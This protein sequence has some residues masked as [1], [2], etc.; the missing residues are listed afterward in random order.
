M[1]NFLARPAGSLSVCLAA[2]V[3]KFIILER[4]NWESLNPFDELEVRTNE[5]TLISRDDFSGKHLIPFWEN[6]QL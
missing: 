1:P 3:E 2:I 6:V 5:V 4:R